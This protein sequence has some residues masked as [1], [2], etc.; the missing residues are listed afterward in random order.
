MRFLLLGLLFLCDSAWGQLYDPTTS[1]WT[2]V[3]DGQDDAVVGI[4][5]NHDFTLYGETF[6]NVWFSSNGFITF[7]DP[8][9][10]SATQSDGGV[11][12][13]DPI[14]DAEWSYMLAPL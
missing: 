6:Q 4:Y 14:A 8:Q 9:T 10:D 1:E 11:Y 12:L 13:P 5:L 3:M 7:Y 2:Q